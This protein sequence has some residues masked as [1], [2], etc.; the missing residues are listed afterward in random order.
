[1][2]G[3]ENELVIGLTEGSPV[4]AEEIGRLLID[5]QKDYRRLFKRQLVLKSLVTGSVWMTVGEYILMGGAGTIGAAKFVEASQR[6]Y[7]FGMQIR[8][9][10]KS[11]ETPQ[12][13]TKA[14]ASQ[15]I[16]LR[17][18]ERLLK[19]AASHNAGL[20]VHVALGPDGKPQ[21]A[22]LRYTPSQANQLHRNSQRA[23]K[24]KQASIEWDA[25]GL[26]ETPKHSLEASRSL[27]KSA[28]ASLGVLPSS[29][30]DTEI[31]AIIGPIAE[32]LKNAGQV[33]LLKEF[34]RSM[35]RAGRHDVA[36]VIQSYI[37][38]DPPKPRAILIPPR[39]K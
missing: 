26:V 1:M 33:A 10:L 30:S 7:K 4:S 38:P 12:P 36:M 19:I 25:S 22:L 28:K 31:R 3:E 18:T 29:G 24:L 21:E 13:E 35:Q 16:D 23:A 17:G 9:S 20:D 8:D 32:I 27:L 39:P 14:P 2:A 37:P 6:L 15:A 5:L 34:S 11:K